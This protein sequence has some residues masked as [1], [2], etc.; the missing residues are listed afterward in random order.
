MTEWLS[1]PTPGWPLL[2]GVFRKIGVLAGVRTDVGRLR[3]HRDRVSRLVADKPY[4]RAVF[5]RGSSGRDEMSP[6]SDIDLCAVSERSFGARVR[7]LLFWWGIRADS[8]LRRYP[9]EARWIDA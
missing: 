9:L 2:Y 6:T 8:V 4:F 5:L 1:S 3:R 7:A